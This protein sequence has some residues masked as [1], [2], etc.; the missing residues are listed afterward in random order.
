MKYRYWKIKLIPLDSRC[1]TPHEW[2]FKGKTRENA[3]KSALRY[4]KKDVKTCGFQIY[5]VQ[6]VLYECD[7]NGR[8]KA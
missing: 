7:H 8:R 3:I 1:G 6:E 2:V 4:C 5:G